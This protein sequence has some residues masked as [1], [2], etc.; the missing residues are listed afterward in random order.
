MARHLTPE[1]RDWIAQLNHEGCQQSEIAEALNRPR[2]TISRELRRNATRGEYHAA[3]AHAEAQ[4][5]RRERPF[6]RKADRA[7]TNAFIRC[8]LASYWSPQQIAGRLKHEFPDEPRRHVSPQTIYTWIDG[9][10]AEM[11]QHWREFLR[12]RGR[13]PR[14]KLENAE[15]RAANASIADRPAVIEQRRRLGDFEG[16]TVLGTPGSGGLVTLVDRRSRY[17]IV[18][19]T[20]N[21]DSRRVRRRIGQRLNELDASRRRSITFDNG[22]EFARCRL[23]EKALGMRIYFAQPGRPCQRGTNENTNGLI[24]QFYPKGTDF[25]T[26]SHAEVATTENLIN[27]RPRACLGYRTPR[28]VFHAKRTQSGCN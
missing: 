8:G 4:R 26:V 25:R 16:D 23:L 9:Q 10:E 19:K 12:R 21:K 11:R 14:R 5:R 18:A 3:R 17:A 27:D 2:C 13:R 6:V 24:R 15:N 22:G 7:Q 1:E 28:E 20:K